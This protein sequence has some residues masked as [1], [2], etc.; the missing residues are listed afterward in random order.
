VTV[1][2]QLIFQDKCVQKT[3]QKYVCVEKKKEKYK[4]AIYKRTTI[5]VLGGGA[6]AVWRL[7]SF[8]LFWGWVGG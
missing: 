3:N 4:Q 6:V 5:F 8:S 2:K 1:C 7:G